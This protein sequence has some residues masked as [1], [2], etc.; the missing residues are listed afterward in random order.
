MKSG[1]ADLKYDPNFNSNAISLT[2]QDD[3]NW[4]GE[5]MKNGTLKTTR[6]IS[7]EIVLQFLLYHDE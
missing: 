1:T 6:Q 3:G 2:K 5:M 7:P 4:I